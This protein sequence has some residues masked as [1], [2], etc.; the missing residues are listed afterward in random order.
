LI[1]FCCAMTGGVE[2]RNATNAA[3]ATRVIVGL[4]VPLSKELR[5][6]LAFRV[7]PPAF[8]CHLPAQFDRQR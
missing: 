4:I 7:G 5:R 1:V 2:A 8:H 6:A 3:L